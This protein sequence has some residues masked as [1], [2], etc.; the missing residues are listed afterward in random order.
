MKGLKNKINIVMKGFVIFCL[1]VLLCGCIKYKNTSD[2][3][4]IIWIHNN[5][6]K[7]IHYYHGDCDGLII[8]KNTINKYYCIQAG[9]TKKIYRDGSFEGYIRLCKSRLLTF[10]FYD[11]EVLKNVPYDTI[12]RYQMVLSIQSYTKAQLDSLDW[13]ISYPQ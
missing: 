2:R 4:Q 5:S 9:T 7:N 10:V 11:E 8:Y 13:H 1:V 6:D 12:Y 3:H